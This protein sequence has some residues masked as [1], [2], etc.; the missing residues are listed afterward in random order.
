MKPQPLVSVVTA[1]YNEAQFLEET[2]LS[3]V[4]Q[5]YKNWELILVDDGS[6]DASPTIAKRFAR[7]YPDRIYYYMHE[8]HANKGVCRS[9]NLGISKA[10][11][12]FIAYLDADDVW[13]EDKLENQIEIF[14]NHPEATVLLEASTYWYSWEDHQRDDVIIEVGAQQNRLYHPP[15]LLFHLYPLGKGAAPCPSGMMVRSKV[16]DRTLFVED[17]IGPTAVY[18]DQAFLTQ[19]YLKES[20]YISSQSNNLYR[21]R[22]ASQVFNVHNEGRYHEVRLYFLEW[23]GRYLKNNNMLSPEINRLLDR[24]LFPYRYPTLNKVRRA[25]SALKWKLIT[26]S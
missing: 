7:S 10:K 24:N 4:N 2:I 20:V 12:E 8:N 26:N 5:R 3:V 25:L 23:F 21:Q 19:L 15:D 13:L 22:V 9:R 16:H 6:P 11:G 14:S 17:F 1:F 18:E